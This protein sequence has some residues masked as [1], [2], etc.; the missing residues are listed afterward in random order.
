[1]MMTHRNNSMTTTL[2]M[3]LTSDPQ[4]TRTNSLCG[5]LSRT[6]QL[7][8]LPQLLK[9]ETLDQQDRTLQVHGVRVGQL[10]ELWRSTPPLLLK[11]C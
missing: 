2:L 6:L 4:R 5:P 10:N 3:L 7:L 8:R 1:M 9:L 11:S